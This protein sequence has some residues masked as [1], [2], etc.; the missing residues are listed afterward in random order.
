MTL[1]RPLW[2]SVST[3]IWLVSTRVKLSST[4]LTT[5]VSPMAP[6]VAQKS[7]GSSLG[8]S[9]SVPS[10]VTRRIERT[11]VAK[12]PSTWW[13]LPWTSAATAPPI[14]TWRVPGV[15]GTNHPW[16]S[17]LFTSSSI[18]VPA[19]TVTTPS[20]TGPM[21]ESPRFERTTPALNCAASP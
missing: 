6:I 1:S 15:T 7:S 12:E 16:G 20:T 2:R 8:E 21:E 18:D 4:E 5:P 19:P 13:F 9:C 10:G 14:V 17:V 11:W 3:T